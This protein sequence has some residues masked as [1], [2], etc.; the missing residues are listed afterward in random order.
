MRGDM[1]GA[2]A[3]VSTCRAIASLRLPIN[4]RGL[5]PL[6]EHMIGCNAIKPGDVV[7]AM[8]GKSIEV[9]VN[10][11]TYSFIFK[12]II[13]HIEFRTLTMKV[14]S[15]WLMHCFTHKSLV[16]DLLSMLEPC[17][18]T[19]FPFSETSLRV[20]SQIRRIFGSR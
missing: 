16:P 17:P 3:V 4:L 20:Y 5:I 11:H 12:I 7:K 9:E 10:F 15:Y 18:L 2:A 6:C 14:L 19:S 13:N 8:N 1:C